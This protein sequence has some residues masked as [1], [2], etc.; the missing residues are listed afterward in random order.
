MFPAHNPFARPSLSDESFRLRPRASEH[1]TVVMDRPGA[2]MDRYANAV[3]TSVSGVSGF[4]LPAQQQRQQLAPMSDV[5]NSQYR[6]PLER[7]V[8]EDARRNPPRSFLTE[9]E[10]SN[11]HALLT[12]AEE[13]RKT[14]PPPPDPFC[15]S[16]RHH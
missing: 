2:H 1:K 11:A 4:Q 5:T 7:I 6:S 10:R 8:G 13:Q 9:A 16:T 14:L 12:V 3:A 15:S